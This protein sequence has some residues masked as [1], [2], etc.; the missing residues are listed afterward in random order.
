MG[1]KK[2]LVKHISFIDSCAAVVSQVAATLHPDIRCLQS[3]REEADKVTPE[4]RNEEWECIYIYRKW[5][6]RMCLLRA[7]LLFCLLRKGSQA[8][9]MLYHCESSPHSDSSIFA[10]LMSISLVLL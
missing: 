9:V 4:E 8:T 10:M 7:R 5:L 3:T 6:L 1:L 2:G